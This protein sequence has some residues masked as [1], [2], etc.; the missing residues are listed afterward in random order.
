[1]R[2]RDSPLPAS[3]K[4]SA[5]GGASL[6]R[7]GPGNKSFLAVFISMAV[8]TWIL[9]MPHT[10]LPKSSLDSVP[11]HTYTHTHTVLWRVAGGDSNTAAKPSFSTTTS[12]PATTTSSSSSSS[13]SSTSL[14]AS[15]NARAPHTAAPAPA[16][17]PCS[18]GPAPAAAGCN[19]TS[20][21]LSSRACDH[22]RCPWECGAC[23]SHGGPA[24]RLPA[25]LSEP[26]AAAALP[27]LAHDA[28][29]DPT[30][31][32]RRRAASGGGSIDDFVSE[33]KGLWGATSYV[34][35]VLFFVLSLSLFFSLF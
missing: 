18:G 23:A 14:S 32:R 22:A 13:S 21:V 2:A 26:T 9:R 30:L 6:G 35:F 7:R 29:I 17:H 34:F 19:A 24:R 25:D 8:L 5:S 27:P 28:G 31:L 1:M 10:P 16:A 4:R 3:T 33:R 12:S 11:L 15:H 20:A